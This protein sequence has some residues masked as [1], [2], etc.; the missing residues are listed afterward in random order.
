MLN[1]YDEKWVSYHKGYSPQSGR[2]N[3]VYFVASLSDGFRYAKCTKVTVYYKQGSKYYSKA[4]K[5]YQD[6]YPSYD[7][8]YHY[9]PYGYTCL[10]NNQKPYKITVSYIPNTIINPLFLIFLEKI[11]L[12]LFW[13]EFFKEK[14]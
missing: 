2:S 3:E 13:Y 7:G 4:L 1:K 11:F 12:D 14:S 9:Y 8:Y 10:K 5:L 6:N